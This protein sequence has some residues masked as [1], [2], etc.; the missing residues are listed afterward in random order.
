MAKFVGSMVKYPARASFI[1]YFAVI[2]AGALVLA[3]PRCTAE[4]RPP[5][6]FLDAL[7]TASSATCVTGLTVRSTANDF[8][9][10][11]QAVIL[12]L[13]QLGGIGIMTVT[14]FATVR[15][16]S[17]QSLRQRVLAMETLGVD[18]AADLRL[19]LRNV[20]LAMLAI[21]AVGFLLLAARNLL[22][23]SPATALWNALF[24]TIS[25]FCNAGFALHD[26]SF[27]RY[28]G[29]LWVNAVVMAL[30]VT[31]GIGFPVILDLRR[32]WRKTWAQLWDGLHLHSK[33]MLLGT[34]VLI[35]FGAVAFLALEWNGILRDM[36]LGRKLLVSG[37]QSITPRT[38]GFNTVDI[39]ALTSATL[40]VLM[41]LMLVG[42]GPCSTAGGFKVSTLA[43]L[44][45]RA[46]SVFRGHER[47]NLFR[48][49]IPAEVVVRANATALVFAA[50]VLFALT[51]LLVFEQ[52]HPPRPQSQGLFLDASF[53]VI[54]A[55]GTVGLSTGLTPE[56]TPMGRITI[57]IAMLIGRLGPISVFV[58]LSQAERTPS[59]EYSQEE[60][61]I[62]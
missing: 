47:V 40:L 56:L 13:I 18:A 25:A 41:L 19:V 48:R 11:G 61:L 33:L 26:D 36:S 21:E 34:P 51:S 50:V 35:A 42:A 10:L 16:G 9:L 4:G 17:R 60:P 44:V 8:S 53:E 24:H 23:L 58:A 15:L 54:S 59:L 49:T 3:H 30:I 46:W 29:D 38:A 6:S 45:L 37:F 52:G 43:V 22:E 31:G 57:I 32:H 7:F 55:L 62:G 12:G 5:L 20:I 14:T 1:A 27:T 2:L 28:Q 39:G